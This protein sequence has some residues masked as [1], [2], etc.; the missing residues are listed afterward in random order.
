METIGISCSHCN[1]ETLAEVMSAT[2]ANCF[3]CAKPHSITENEYAFVKRDITPLH[4]I[5]QRAKEQALKDML[6]EWHLEC[7]ENYLDEQLDSMYRR[8]KAGQDACALDAGIIIDWSTC[9]DT[10][11]IRVAI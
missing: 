8:D 10:D 7:N 11:N 3:V 4:V 2:H 5:E 6:D 1:T 9:F